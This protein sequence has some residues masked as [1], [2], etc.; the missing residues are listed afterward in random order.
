MWILDHTHIKAA[1]GKVYISMQSFPQVLFCN[2][3]SLLQNDVPNMHWNRMPSEHK[4][5]NPTWCS[6][7]V[8]SINMH[9]IPFI[10]SLSYLNFL[11]SAGGC[12]RSWKTHFAAGFSICESGFLNCQPKPC[13]LAEGSHQISTQ[14]N[15][16]MSW[17]YF[18]PNDTKKNVASHQ[19]HKRFFPPVSWRNKWR[20][21]ISL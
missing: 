6:R 11:C 16:K 3:V 8:L 4:A 19:L 13:D 10:I 17:W 20:W 2:L 9:F 21:Y 18:I 15:A 5:Q 1:V 7:V 14:T 12:W